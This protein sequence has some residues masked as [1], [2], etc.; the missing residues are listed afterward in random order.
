[1]CKQYFQVFHE[2]VHTSFFLNCRISEYT[3]VSDASKQSNNDDNEIVAMDR[4][5]EVAIMPENIAEEDFDIIM[6]CL[7]EISK[8][9]ENADNLLVSGKNYLTFT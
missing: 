8:V 5:H 9:I 1:M 2:F 6:N 3:L 4:E 7:E